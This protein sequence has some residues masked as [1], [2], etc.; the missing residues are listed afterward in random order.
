MKIAVDAMGGD[1][2]PGE[3][4]KGALLAAKEYNQALILVG[5]EE[6][7]R[8]EMGSHSLD[9]LISIVHAPEVIQM[10]EQ[11]AVSVRRKK[12][13]SIVMAT[14]LVKEGEA[15][16]LVSAGS[17][18]AAM[19]AALL[20]LGRIQGIDRPAIAGIL[21]SVK[22]FTVLLDIGANTDCKPH[23]LL[24]FGIMG[25]LYAKNIL[26]V[27]EP[28]VGLLSNG[29][30]KTKGNETTLAAFPLLADAGINFT[31]NVEGRD[32]FCGNVDVVVCDGF[33]GNI[34]L[35]AGEG[36]AMALY[37]M[38]K[39]E[40]T[41]S[42]LAKMGMLMAEPALRMF[43]MRV[44]YAEYGGA[45]LLGVDGISIIC[46]GSSTSRALKNGIRVARQ[47][48]ER[49]LVRSIRESIAGSVQR[50]GAGVNLARRID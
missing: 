5:D 35:K 50:K 49:G 2:A 44:D 22:G 48:L 27:E 25:Y 17:T 7:I 39:E 41:K 24:Q 3:I 29:E 28:R 15:S 9:N 14:R 33:V 21:P 13:S 36:L 42:W 8:A 47:S 38:M 32:I 11:P 26:G 12:N 37:K 40:I 20:G 10:N 6:Q 45:P 19:A 43:K 46:H 4:V 34:V 23:N 18:G 16:A 31:G 30:E 1:F